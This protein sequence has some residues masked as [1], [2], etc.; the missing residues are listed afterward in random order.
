MKPSSF[1]TWAMLRLTLLAGISTT[2]RSM[3]LALRMRVSRSA[4][5]P[6]IMVV[7]SLPARFLNTRDQAI[8]CHVSETDPANAKLAIHCP[9]P[10]A[11]L[12]AQ[13]NAD[14]FPRQHLHRVR[15]LPA[16][17][18]LCQLAAKLHVF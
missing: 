5:G 16:G 1:K 11:E 10:A 17:F 8:A 9:R 14:F 18:E 12:A 4:I 13:S 7:R 3:R 15:L 6:F 2:A